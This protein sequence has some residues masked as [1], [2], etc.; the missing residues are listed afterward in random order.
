MV[1]EKVITRIK[2]L[3]KKLITAGVITYIMVCGVGCNEVNK[4]TEF[5]DGINPNNS[6]LERNSGSSVG[7][8]ILFQMRRIISLFILYFSATSF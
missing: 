3:G 4:S 1:N 6:F 7:S 8:N 5:Q 2:Y